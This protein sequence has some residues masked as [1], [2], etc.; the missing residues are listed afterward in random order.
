MLFNLLTHLTWCV[1]D[2]N[3]PADDRGARSRGGSVYVSGLVGEGSG[4]WAFQQGAISAEIAQ[5]F[6][7]Q[8]VFL[9]EVSRFPGSSQDAT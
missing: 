4:G 3:C 9:A 8:P 1:R 7:H 2:S 6:F 5:W